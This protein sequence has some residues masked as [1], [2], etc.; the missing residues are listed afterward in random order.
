[1]RTPDTAGAG[2]VGLARSRRGAGSLG[3]WA[4]RGR[5]QHAPSALPCPKRVVSVSILRSSASLLSERLV[6]VASD[7]LLSESDCGA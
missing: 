4:L 2:G 7:W 5:G 6:S 3:P 1:M